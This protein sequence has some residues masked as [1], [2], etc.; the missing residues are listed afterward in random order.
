[1]LVREINCYCNCKPKIQERTLYSPFFY[2]TELFSFN[3]SNGKIDCYWLLW[4]VHR[5]NKLCYDSYIGAIVR[6]LCKHKEENIKHGTKCMRTKLRS[7]VRND[8][9]V[10]MTF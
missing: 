9:D 7:V 3:I 1:M 8:K 5:K 4:V 6:E 2:F 10:F